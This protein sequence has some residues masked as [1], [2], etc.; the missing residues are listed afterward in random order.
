MEVVHVRDRLPCICQLCLV[1]LSRSS[2][3]SLLALNDLPQIIELALVRPNQIEL[4][5]D[6]AHHA[7]EGVSVGIAAKGDNVDTMLA[8][9]LARIE[10]VR[11]CRRRESDVAGGQKEDPLALAALAEV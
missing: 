11:V 1:V 8:R 7:L 4:A 2:S 5:P 3:P 6:F 9:L 10:L